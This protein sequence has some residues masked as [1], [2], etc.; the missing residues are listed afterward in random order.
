MRYAYDSRD[1]VVYYVRYAITA[2]GEIDL[3]AMEC[4]RLPFFILF[5]C[6]A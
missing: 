6:I 3:Q 5:Y 1:D 4:K 2:C